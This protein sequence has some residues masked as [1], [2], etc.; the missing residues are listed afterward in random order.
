M[1]PSFSCLKKE[2][3][4][5]KPFQN[6][7]REE[8]E[9][10]KEKNSTMETI[11]VEPLFARFRRAHHVLSSN[12]LKR[13]VA[14]EVISL[15]LSLPCPRLEREKEGESFPWRARNRT[16]T[17]HVCVL[18]RNSKTPQPRCILD[19]ERGQRETLFLPLLF[20]EPSPPYFSS[21][22]SSYV[23]ALPFAFAFTTRIKSD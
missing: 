5:R 4:N 3:K 8:E 19:D 13:S 18:S 21:P 7:R 10:K 12:V 16:I 9:E 1:E 14:V 2:K 23:R 11:V 17:C 22:P 6:G 15:F 20:E